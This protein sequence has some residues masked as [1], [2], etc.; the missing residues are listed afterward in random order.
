MAPVGILLDALES[1]R[2]MVAFGDAA[3]DVLLIFEE[4]FGAP[5]SDT[6]WSE[7]ATCFAPMVRTV[8]YGDKEIVFADQDID[9]GE[10]GI[11]ATFEQWYVSGPWAVDSSIWTLS[12]ICIGSTVADIRMAY[13]DNFSI[14][15][16]IDGDLSGFFI[17]DSTGSGD[18]I[19]GLSNTT[20]DTGIV[21][22][23]WAGDVC[24]RVLS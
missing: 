17:F 22:D 12:R 21:L 4:A 24:S 5:D 8:T 13:P 1:D 20:E 15:L 9:D 16:A 23:L 6:G 10:P 3:D 11:G 2:N 14:E 19:R 18:G 7:N